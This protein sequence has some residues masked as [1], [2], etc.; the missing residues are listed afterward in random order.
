MVGPSRC[1]DRHHCTNITSGDPEVTVPQCSNTL[2]T[3]QSFSTEYKKGCFSKAKYVFCVVKEE[4]D[5]RL[6]I[7]STNCFVLLGKVPLYSQSGFSSIFEHVGSCKS[8]QFSW[9]H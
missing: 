7:F 3:A 4:R 8:F 5:S 1:K 6:I 2:K 9:I